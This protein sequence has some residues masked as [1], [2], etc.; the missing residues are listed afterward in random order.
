MRQ[1]KN[2]RENHDGLVGGN[3]FEPLKAEPTDLQ[4]APFDRFGTLP[5]EIVELVDGLEPPTC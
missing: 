4:S 5:N 2:R 1:K 3:G